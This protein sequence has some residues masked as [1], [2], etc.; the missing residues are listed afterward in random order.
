MQEATPNSRKSVYRDVLDSLP[1]RYA[2]RVAVR[3]GSPSAMLMLTAA[4]LRPV[5]LIVG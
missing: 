4:A 2:R 5:L 1:P 3:D